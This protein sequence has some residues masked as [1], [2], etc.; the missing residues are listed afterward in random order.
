MAFQGLGRRQWHVT[1]NEAVARDRLGHPR[2]D[3]RRG[4]PPSVFRV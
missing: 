3:T 4:T 1:A 2:S